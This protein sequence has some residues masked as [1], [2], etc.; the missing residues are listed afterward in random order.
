MIFQKQALLN[1]FKNDFLIIV[2]FIWV[3]WKICFFFDKE[4]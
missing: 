2:V 1:K 4:N 3:Q